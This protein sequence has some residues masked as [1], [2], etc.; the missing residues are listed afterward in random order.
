MID[1]VSPATRPSEQEPQACRRALLRQSRPQACARGAACFAR[2]NSDEPSND[3]LPLHTPE[4]RRVKIAQLKHA[5]QR[6]TYQSTPEQIAEQVILE[7]LIDIL[8]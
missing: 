1:R 5:L 8:V 3:A 6:G 7:T 2:Q 4:G